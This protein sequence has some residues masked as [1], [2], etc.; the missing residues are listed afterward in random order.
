[1]TALT[2]A[3]SQYYVPMTKLL[4]TLENLIG[5]NVGNR[6]QLARYTHSGAKVSFG[7]TYSSKS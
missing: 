6:V 1:M 4:I 3:V 2:S 7:V 5:C